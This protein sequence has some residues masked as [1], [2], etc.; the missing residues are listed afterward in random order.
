M[1]S[2]AVPVLRGLALVAALGWGA[3]DCREAVTPTL[4]PPGVPSSAPVVATV[5]SR[6]TLVDSIGILNIEVTAH[7]AS[8]IDS[9]ALSI[10]GAALAFPA[11]HPMDTVFEGFFSIPLAGLRH[12]PFSFTVTA[13]DI[14]GHD[15][16]TQSV[17]VRLR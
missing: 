9:V 12:Q 11:A 17:T 13:G 5:P 8:L 1:N 14:L 15:T 16:T 7:S 3:W 4:P 10:E 6:D 2:T